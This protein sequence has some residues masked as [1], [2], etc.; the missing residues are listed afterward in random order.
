MTDNAPGT[1]AS[2]HPMTD[3][4]LDI[5]LSTTRDRLEKGLRRTINAQQRLSDALQESAPVRPGREHPRHA[6][7]PVSTIRPGDHAWLAFSGEPERDRVIGAFVRDGLDM[8]EKMV[9]IADDEARQLLGVLPRHGYDL[10]ALM[11]GG[12]LS[13]IPREEACMDS[14]GRF[15][16]GRMLQTLAQQVDEA[17]DQGF[18]AVR[19]TT[20]L[21][22]ALSEPGR[23]T[24]NQMLGCEHRLG[25]NVFST[26]MTMAICQVDRRCCSK[27]DLAALGDS[28]EIVVEANP[29]FDDGILRIVRTFEPPGLRLE[30]EIDVARQAILK[31]LLKTTTS[32]D[33]T[34]LDISRLGFID[35]GGLNVLAQ[36]ARQLPKHAP[37]VLDNVPRQIL[38]VIE[39]VGWQH[40]PGFVLG[41]T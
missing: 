17:F 8:N 9:Y 6:R 36:H 20:D 15:D 23:P 11:R 25:E 40:Q 7:H 10:P 29:E 3:A 1:A 34:H 18:R 33:P 26:S 13:F 24:L 35:L 30:G 5:L 16:A 22:W 4:E 19:M 31:E 37:L 2:S 28:H 21:T 41:R 39:M 12:Q 14:R 27:E 38:A 32:D